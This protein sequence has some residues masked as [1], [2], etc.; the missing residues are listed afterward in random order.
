MKEPLA[1]QN[2][3]LYQQRLFQMNPYLSTSHGAADVFTTLLFQNHLHRPTLDSEYANTSYP[4]IL[5]TFNDKQVRQPPAEPVH[6]PTPL[7]SDLSISSAIPISSPVFKVKRIKLIVRRPP[8]TLTDPR[9]RPPPPKFNNSLPRFLNSYIS[10]DDAEPNA[11]ALAR[12]A[13]AEAATRERVEHFRIA[14]RFIPGTDVLFGTTPPETPYTPPQRTTRD[15]WDDVVDA[16]VAQAK[17]RPRRP[18]GRAVAAQV[19]S[20]I[21]AHFA[22]KETRRTKARVSEEKQLRILAKNTIRAVVLEW[23]K[24][25]HVSTFFV[26]MMA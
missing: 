10:I 9:Q 2:Q 6:T 15:I 18:I 12:A 3:Q 5:L 1:V 24:A 20:R 26:R 4:R 16:V 11:D 8:P 21:Q 13:Q 19:A 25:V 14:G 7:V 17:A 23:K 22:G